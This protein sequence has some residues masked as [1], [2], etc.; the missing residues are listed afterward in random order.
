MSSSERAPEPPLRLLALTHSLGGGGAERFV[1]TL[2]THLD[3]ASFRPEVCAATGRASYPLAAD[4][5]VTALG[6]RG[7]ADPAAHGAAA[8]AAAARAAAGSAAEQR[9]L[10][11]RA[12]RRRAA[13]RLAAAAVG[14]THRQRARDRRARASSAGGRG[15]PTRWPRRWSPTRAAGSPPSRGVILRPPR[16]ST[17]C[18]IRPTSRGSTGWRRSRQ[19]VSG[20]ASRS[21]SGWGG[22]RARSG[23]ISCSRRAPRSRGSGRCAS[24]CAVRDRCGAPSRRKSRRPVSAP[25]W[26][27][28]VSWRTR[29]R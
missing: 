11:Q 4:V 14:G 6:Y 24:G 8:A 17:I 13:R 12:G 2:A 28:W 20:V 1:A 29:S 15:A 5:P 22:W 21:W 10:D 18:P 27:S 16:A 19:R 25:R 3:R 7:L 23:R 9:A 26:S